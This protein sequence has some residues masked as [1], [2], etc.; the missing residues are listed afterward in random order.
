MSESKNV[1]EDLTPN[2][3]LPEEAKGQ[4]MDRLDA[5]RLMLDFWDLFAPKRVAVNLN[6][7]NQS[8]SNHKKKEK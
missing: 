6:A 7:L 2:E 8:Q 3:K 1:F 4:V 5:A